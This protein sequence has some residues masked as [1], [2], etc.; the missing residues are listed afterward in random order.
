[1]LPSHTLPPLWVSTVEIS[2][3][4][5][6]SN[7]TSHE[8]WIGLVYL[9]ETMNCVTVSP[10]S[11]WA[12]GKLSPNVL[13]VTGVKIGMIDHFLSLI[14]NFS[15]LVFVFPFS[16][17]S[18]FVFIMSCYALHILVSSLKSSS[19]IKWSVKSISHSKDHLLLC[20]CSDFVLLLSTSYKNLHP[21][22]LLLDHFVCALDVYNFRVSEPVCSHVEIPRLDKNVKYRDHLEGAHISLEY[23]H[24]FVSSRGK[25]IFLL[26]N[27]N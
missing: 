24:M 6:K 25:V 14:S 15:V 23:L 16:F 20:H 10:S 18:I 1:M 5:T 22:F 8:Q 21:D 12:A 3:F 7:C 4:C 27:K 9:F 19:G 11:S 13:A 17:P 2:N 26:Q